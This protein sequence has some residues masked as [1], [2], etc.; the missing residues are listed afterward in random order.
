M[1]NSIAVVGCGSSAVSFLHSVEAMPTIGV[2][3]ITIPGALDCLQK[4]HQ[5]SQ[6]RFPAHQHP[7]IAYHQCN[8]GDIHDA[9]NRGDWTTVEN[10]ILDSINKL[11]DLGADF[12]IMPANTPHRMIDSI[13]RR[14]PDVPVLNM[15]DFVSQACHEKAWK[16]V[17]VLGTQ[18][19]MKDHLYQKSLNKYHI[20]EII[21]SEADQAIVQEAIFNELIPT[22]KA[23]AETLAKLVQVVE[24][25]K[26][27][28]CDGVILGCTELPLVLNNDNSPIP[29][30]DSTFILATAAVTQAQQ[31]LI[32]KQGIKPQSKL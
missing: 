5:L 17:G 18:W 7:K 13:I 24:R 21:P 26:A 22:G 9:Q 30:L 16:K 14:S 11:K 20:T 15:L 6:G 31:L 23:S 32:N 2:A 4:I 8:F 29:T 3:G 12:I 10:L 19:T 1:T 28:G 25:L 27:Q